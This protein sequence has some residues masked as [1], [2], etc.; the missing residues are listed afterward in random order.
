MAERIRALWQRLSE[1]IHRNP[2][3]WIGVGITAVVAVIAYL[4]YRQNQLKTQADVPANGYGFPNYGSAGFGSSGG[5]LGGGYQPYQPPTP[6]S[7]GNIFTPTSSGTLA[8]G[9]PAFPAFPAFTFGTAAPAAPVAS[10]SSTPTIF[11]S[12]QNPFAASEQAHTGRLSI[13]GSIQNPLAVSQQAH[14]LTGYAAP[15]PIA[16]PLTIVQ[17]SIQNPTATQENEHTGKTSSPVTS[18]PAPI[19]TTIRPQ[20][21]SAG[22]VA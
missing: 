12:I 22:R 20:A 3:L 8:S 13:F 4:A 19:Y 14:T 15:A 5:G 1:D 11:G 2:G 10:A 7:D 18:Y 16:P 21:T 9:F 17:G 6:S